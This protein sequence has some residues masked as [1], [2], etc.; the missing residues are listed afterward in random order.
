M[1]V[2]PSTLPV[3]KYII[4]HRGT[5]HV[6]LCT[7]SVPNKYFS[8]P[9]SPRRRA[10]PPAPVPSSSSSHPIPSH[11]ITS[12]YIISQRCDERSG[13]RDSNHDRSMMYDEIIYKMYILWSS[14]KLKNHGIKYLLSPPPSSSLLSLSFL[15][16]L[17]FVLYLSFSLLAS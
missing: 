2:R 6:M 15:F 9:S 14:L 13:T 11:H 4:I 3:P 5:A 12:H 7:I 1:V 10:A 16:S 17:S 8:S